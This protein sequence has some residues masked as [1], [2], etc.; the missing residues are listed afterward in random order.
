MANCEKHSKAIGAFCSHTEAS[1]QLDVV[2]KKTIAYLMD[3]LKGIHGE[4]WNVQQE[5][6]GTARV[7]LWLGLMRGSI[8]DLLILTNLLA[9]TTQKIDLSTDLQLFLHGP[10]PALLSFNDKPVPI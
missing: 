10:R 1:Y 2:V 8:Q 9:T 7:L 6:Q 5:Y 4:T 3:R